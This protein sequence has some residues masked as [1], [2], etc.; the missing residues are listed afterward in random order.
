MTVIC[1]I[2]AI[3]I[4]VLLE[5]IAQDPT[6]HRFSD[7]RTFWHTLNCWNVLSNIPFLLTGGW[8]LLQLRRSNR[9]Q[10]AH[11]NR[12]AYWLFFAG[13]L[14]VSAG[15]SY[16]HVDPGNESLVWDRLPMTIGFMAL[17]SIIISEFVSARLG[18]RLLLP[19]LVFGCFSVFYW[20]FT[21]SMG[22]G[23][24]RLYLIVQ[25]LPMLLAPI[26]MVVYR[27]RF[28]HTSGYW[29]LFLAY[30]AAKV[31][32]YYDGAVYSLTGNVISGHSLKHIVA[33]S[34]V[35]LLLRSYQL[36]TD[37]QP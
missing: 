7:S 23:D 28:T 1:V 27:S 24:L 33:A 19:L 17:F 29:L 3:V 21:E 11:E 14:L 6:Y 8:G 2:G 25:F 26:I 36:R 31:L 5:P 22:Q 15:S 13:V 35:F 37:N 10:I 34:G 4:L 16:Y 30:I 32:E 9:L 18:K 12:L 20:W